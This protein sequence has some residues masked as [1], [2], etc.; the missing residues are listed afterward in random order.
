[1]RDV[2]PLSMNTFWPE[3]D[4]GRPDVQLEASNEFPD[5][6]GASCQLESGNTP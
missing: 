4:V 6:G 2:P 5:V 3:L 1:M